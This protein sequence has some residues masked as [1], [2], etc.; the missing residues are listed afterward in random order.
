ML[1]VLT[2]D[3]Y[4]R[5]AESEILAN[6][7]SVIGFKEWHS[8]LSLI[9]FAFQPIVNIHS[10]VCYGCEALLRNYEAAGFAS[11]NDFFDRAYQDRV[12]YPVD[13]ELRRKCIKNF[14]ILKKRQQAKL[15]FN[16]DNRVLDSDDYKSGNTLRILEAHNLHQDAICFEISEKHELQ[17]TGEAV[18][19]LKAYRAQGFKIAVDDCGTGFSGLKLLYYTRPDF[20]KIDRFFIQDIATDPNKRMLVSSIVNIAHLMGSI[21]VAEGVETEQ[22]YYS[23]RSIG[24]DLVQ[25]YFIQKP[26]TDILQIRPCYEHIRLLGEKG[27]RK[28]DSHDRSLIDSEIVY[29][30]PIRWDMN[31]Y[32]VFQQFRN[33]QN[34]SF[35]PVI[36]DNGEPLGVISEKSFKDYA[37]SRYGSELLQ[38]PSFGK[39]LNR[40]IL[41]Y[42]IADIHT[43]V[44]K[45][46]EIYS[47]NEHM[48]G[49]II[50]D[51]MKYKGFLSAYSLLKALNEKN[52]TV[53]RDQNPLTRLPGNTLIH[54]Y[55]SCALQDFE[56]SYFFIYFDFDYFKPFN[57]R[58]GFRNGDRVILRFSELLKIWAQL[59]SAFIGH[60]GGDDFFMAFRGGNPEKIKE[61][62]LKLIRQFKSDAESFYDPET[63]EKGHMKSTDRDGNFRMF[64]LMSVSAVILE[65]CAKRQRV[66][67]TEEIGNKMASEK[68]KAK[69]SIDN[70]SICKL[71]TEGEDSP[72]R[73]EAGNLYL[74]ACFS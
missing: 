46:L 28:K 24:C 69:N 6:Y 68:K 30:E 45:I 40:F 50:V 12:L 15:F 47:H 10:G 56:T 9:D 35:F 63:I 42:P 5:F 72:G 21:V 37:Y 38:N 58:Y 65:L 51:E 26:Q 1:T 74:Q 62:V 27:R 73:H 39:N 49:I 54:E 7:A 22:E 31:I 20:I 70:L 60:I 17:D 43:Q 2:G 18:E 55:V 53:A 36:N 71:G 57:D 11:I 52:I 8:R 32:D 44:E 3:K 41:K 16:L 34:Q 61:D 25:G 66:Y 13:L 19:T 33:T 14:S 48:E 29:I 23:C 59:S 67:S 64:P 4:M